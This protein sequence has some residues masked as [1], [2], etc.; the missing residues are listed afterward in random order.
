MLHCQFVLDHAASTAQLTAFCDYQVIS[1]FAKRS[2][3]GFCRTM[4]KALGIG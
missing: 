1:E 4:R 3:R 2:Q